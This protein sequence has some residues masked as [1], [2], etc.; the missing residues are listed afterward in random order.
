MF[1]K[2]RRRMFRWG[3]VLFLIAGAL[4]FFAPTIVANTALRNRIIPMATKDINGSAEIGGMSLG[5][6]SPVGPNAEV[7]MVLTTAGSGLVGLSE[8]YLS[9]AEP[10]ERSRAW[11][12]GV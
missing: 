9:Q 1:A 7:A 8:T 3:F 6:F 4:L 11:P 5:W 2:F 12:A 10:D